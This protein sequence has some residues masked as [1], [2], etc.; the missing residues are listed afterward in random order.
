[1]A[2]CGEFNFD[3]IEI[4]DVSDGSMFEMIGDGFLTEMDPANGNVSYVLFLCGYI[5]CL[6]IVFYICFSFNIMFILYSLICVFV[7]RM[8][9]LSMQVETKNRKS[10]IVV[11][12][13]HKDRSEENELEGNV[14]Q[15]DR[16]ANQEAVREVRAMILKGQKEFQ[17]RTTLVSDQTMRMETRR[18]KMKMKTLMKLYHLIPD[19]Q[20]P[21]IP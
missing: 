6:S 16:H 14:V 12:A 19:R 11:A 2:N 4:S 10:R 1:M 3:N 5:F 17:T 8:S 7:C 13:A 15:R 18:M 9:K 21:L 20:L